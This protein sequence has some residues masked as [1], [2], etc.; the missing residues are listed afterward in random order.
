MPDEYKN[1]TYLGVFVGE[2]PT[3]LSFKVSNDKFLVNASHKNPAIYI[4]ELGKTVMGCESFWHEIE[5]E[6]QLKEIT[7]NDI[8]NV[9]YI[10]ALKQIKK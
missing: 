7:D 10:Q 5:D 8:N 9:W 4:P 2:F 3:G 1:K 6:T